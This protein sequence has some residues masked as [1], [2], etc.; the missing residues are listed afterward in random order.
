MTMHKVGQGRNDGSASWATVVVV[1]NHRSTSCLRLNEGNRPATGRDE[2]TR[3]VAGR[4]VG[5]MV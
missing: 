3:L 5:R 2:R 4:R 1:S